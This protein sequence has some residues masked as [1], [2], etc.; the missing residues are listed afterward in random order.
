[1][2]PPLNRCVR[3]FGEVMANMVFCK[4]ETGRQK[5]VVEGM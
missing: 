3:G 5:V 1:M 2:T 4:I